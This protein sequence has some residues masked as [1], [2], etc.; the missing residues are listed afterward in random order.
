MPASSQS[1]SR[2][3]SVSGTPSTRQIACD[4]SSRAKRVHEVE[5]LVAGGVEE[6]VAPPAQLVGE[7]GD[8]ARREAAVDERAQALVLRVV[9]LVE[10]RAG[11]ALVLDRRAALGPDAAAVGRE[12]DRIAQH[13]ADVGVAADDPEALA[14][15]R[16][17]RSARASDT[18]SWAR[19]QREALVGEAAA[20]R[21]VVGQV[22][23]RRRGVGGS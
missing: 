22:D 21:L 5:R 3:W 10:H 1:S 6:G 2:G 9:G 8:G 14:V 12:R 16:A 19:S 11:R 23:R 13:G 18:G 7:R 4:G 15:G 17:R 20:E